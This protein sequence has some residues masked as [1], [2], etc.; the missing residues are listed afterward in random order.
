[1]IIM[2]IIIIIIIM[3][4][5]IIIIMGFSSEHVTELLLSTVSR[6]NWN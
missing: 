4:I 2:I 3:I 1:M 5:I 6:W